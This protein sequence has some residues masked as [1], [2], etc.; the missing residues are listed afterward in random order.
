MPVIMNK[1]VKRYNL[2]IYKFIGENGGWINF[3]MK[4]I[5]EFNCDTK[6]QGAIRE[7]HWINFYKSDLN[8]MGSYKSN[9]D[10]KEYQKE[11]YEVNKDKILQQKKEYR[12]VKYTCECGKSLTLNN[13]SVHRK[14]CKAQNKI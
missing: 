2:R 7:Q 4:P 3:E 10:K 12:S 6:L 9:E 13:K 1:N 11:Y 5:E 8:S 14:I